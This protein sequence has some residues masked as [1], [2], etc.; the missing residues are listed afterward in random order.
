MNKKNI[1]TSVLSLILIVLLIVFV[2]QQSDKQAIK[3]SASLRLSWI[4]SAS[5]T[6]D[7]AGVTKFAEKNNLNLQVEFGGPG[8]NP[9]QLVAGGTDTF[10]WAGA[11]EVLVANEKGADLVIIG[12]IHYNPPVGFVSLLEKNINT[13]QDFEGKK[14]GILPFGNSTMIYEIMLAQNKVDRK[15]IDEITISSD[16]KPFLSNNYDIHPVF[17]YDETV[18]LDKKNIAY[19]LVKPE[20]FG[21]DHI[22]GYVYF[23]KRSTIEENPQMVED[24]VN[25]MA[26]GWNYAIANQEDALVMLKNFAPE[27]DIDR[28]RQV[29]AR[30]IPYFTAYNNQALNSDLATWTDMVN[31]LKTLEVLKQDVDLNKVLQLQFINKYYEQ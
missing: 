25:V 22:K 26:D 1:I 21:V 24:F 28:E 23:T 7:I 29:L 16:L 30:A 14:V 2:V 15:T 11:D 10:G 13:P 31:E 12:L 9:I 19:K 18:D 6:G 4:P 17:V 8:I 5:F 27:I 20:D 3:N